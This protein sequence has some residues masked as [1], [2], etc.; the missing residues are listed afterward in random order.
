[1]LGPLLCSSD[2]WIT[3]T[4]LFTFVSVEDRKQVPKQGP[5]NETGCLLLAHSLT[6][7][8]RAWPLGSTLEEIAVVCVDGYM[9]SLWTI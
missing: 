1:M 5:R 4:F 2:N 3:C 6:N 8:G 9:I 7:R